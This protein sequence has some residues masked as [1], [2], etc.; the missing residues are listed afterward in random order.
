[1]SAI[2]PGN[3]HA[4][5][6][7]PSYQLVDVRGLGGQRGHY[8]DRPVGRSGAE[9]RLGVSAEQLVTTKEGLGVGLRLGP[10]FRRES[11]E[12]RGHGVQG[13]KDPCL[14]APER[15]EP[16]WHQLDLQIPE[17]VTTQRQVVS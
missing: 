8:S 4:V 16:P 5:R 10:A 3:I 1:M 15:G 2:D 13:G 11:G 6:D 9:H 12:S 7:K 17:I 14:A